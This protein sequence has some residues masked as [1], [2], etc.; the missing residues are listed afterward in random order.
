MS[1]SDLE[2]FGERLVDEDDGDKNSKTLL[3]EARDIS[4]EKAQIKRDNHQQNDHHPETDPETKRQKVHPVLSVTATA[5]VPANDQSI[6]RSC[7]V[8]AVCH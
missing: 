6:M 3:G 1:D 2:C 4:N 8:G 5:T 7:L